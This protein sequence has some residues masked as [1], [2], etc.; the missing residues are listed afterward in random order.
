MAFK[1]DNKWTHSDSVLGNNN[2]NEEHKLI[3]NEPHRVESRFVR[4]KK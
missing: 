2:N 1:D 4:R 3:N